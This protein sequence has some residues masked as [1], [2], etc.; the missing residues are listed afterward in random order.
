MNLKE[1]Y[2]PRTIRYLEL[3]QE[4]EW[5]IK[6]YSICHPSKSTDPA[7]VEACKAAARRLLPQPALTPDRYGVGFMGVHQGRSYDFVTLAWWCYDSELRQH[8]LMRPSSSSYEL[9]PISDAELFSDV[10]DLRLLAFE[11]DA[12]VNEVLINAEGP[13]LD[14]YLAQ[15][16]HETS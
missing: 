12:W 14:A 5:R 9:A 11:R 10:W 15:Q 3:W 16:L 13:D 1:P 2:K 4:A 6:L 7:L 8:T